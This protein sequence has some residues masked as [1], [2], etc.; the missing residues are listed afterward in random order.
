[1]YSI[2]EINITL[3]CEDAVEKQRGLQLNEQWAKNEILRGRLL[4]RHKNQNL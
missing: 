2:M 3:N 4:G 1:M